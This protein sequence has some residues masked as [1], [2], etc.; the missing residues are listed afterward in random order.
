MAK[1]YPRRLPQSALNDPRRAAERKVYAGLGKGLDDSY[2]VFYSVAWLSKP[3]RGSASDGEVDFIVAHPDDGVLLLEVKGGRV[4]RDGDTGKWASIDRYDDAHS[5]KDPIEQVRKSK[6]SLL[7]KLNEHPK[8]GGRR[9]ELGHGIV[10]PDCATPNAPLSADAPHEIVAFSADMEDLGS[11]V[12]Q[13]YRY[14]RSR[15]GDSKL[16]ADGMKIL[17]QLLAPT[18]QLRRPLGASIAEDDRQ[19]LE[20]TEQQY[21][22]LDLLARQ[23]RVSVAGG[24]GTGKTVLAG[25]KAKRLAEEGLRVLLTCYNR[26]L[27]EYLQDRFAWTEGLE[28]LTFH[29]LCYDWA[30]E[31]GNLLP[32][33][34]GDREYFE[35][36]MPEALLAA[37]DKLEKRYDAIVVDEAQDFHETWWDPLQLCLSDPDTGIL[38]VFY[39]D[40]QSI[41]QRA[42]TFPKGLVEISLSENLRNT[43]RIHELAHRFYKGGDT[44]AVGPDGRAVEAIESQGDAALRHAVADLLNR[45]VVEQEV[46]ASQAAILVGK[47]VDRGAFAGTYQLGGVGLTSNQEVEPKK[48]LLQTIHGFKGLERRV[49]VL[50]DI[51]QVPPSIRGELFYVGITRARAHLAVVAERATLKALGLAK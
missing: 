32:K 23:R 46:P 1:M 13:M 45:L 19:I 49:V 3:Q 9:I 43:K 47:S 35:K 38:Y 51:D 6:F 18:F 22:V 2:S 33:T 8:W 50:A 10:L 21:R 26:P 30:E 44:Q 24:A 25:E 4:A 15:H 14:W 37:A 27:A 20:L 40:N 28:I 48:V 5:I 39:D 29:R 34:S 7:D 42:T 36:T 11:K 12:R 31:A 17:T 16:G 41:Y